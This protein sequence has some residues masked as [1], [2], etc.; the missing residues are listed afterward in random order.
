MKLKFLRTGSLCEY[1]QTLMYL[2]RNFR[3]SNDI[4]F[5]LAWFLDSGSLNHSSSLLRVALPMQLCLAI[6][7]TRISLGNFL[8]SLVVT[9]RILNGKRSGLLWRRI[10]TWYS[11]Q[12]QTQSTDLTS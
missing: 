9:N 6:R 2:Y 8:W 11:W 5:F 4:L 1:F 7:Y 12:Q 10:R 3:C